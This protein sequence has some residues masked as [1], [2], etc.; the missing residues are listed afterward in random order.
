MFDEVLKRFESKISSSIIELDFDKALQW[1]EAITEYVIIAFESD[2]ITFE[3]S[4]K[5]TEK[6]SVMT[7]KIKNLKEERSKEDATD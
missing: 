4:M 5:L 3:E 6:Y 1:L 7:R 2:S